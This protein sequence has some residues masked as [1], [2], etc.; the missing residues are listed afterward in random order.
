MTEDL[1]NKT[2]GVPAPDAPLQPAAPP[3][4]RAAPG[5]GAPQASGQGCAPSIPDA[6]GAPNAHEPAASESSLPSEST[7][8]SGAAQPMPEA[9]QFQAPAGA[10]EEETQPAE[11][12]KPQA[13]AMRPNPAVVFLR[14][15]AYL[16]LT[17]AIAAAGVYGGYAVVKNMAASE[18][19][20]PLLDG[21]PFSS[22]LYSKEG[23][24]MRVTPAA[25]GIFRVRAPLESIDKQVVDATIAYEDKNFWKHPGFDAVALIRSAVSTYIGGARTGASTL[26]MQLARM[27]LK[28]KTDTPEGKLKQIWHA[29]RY[30][31]HYSKREILEAYLNLAPYGS[32]VEGVEAAAAVWFHKTASHLTPAEAAALAVIPQN[33]VKR[34][35]DPVG[36][37]A[38]DAARLRLSKLLVESGAY[39]PSAASA[40]RAPLEVFG[41]D[42]LP[43]LAPH[44]AQTVLTRAVGTKKTS[45]A[46]GTTE[47][48]DI[49]PDVTSGRTSGRLSGTLSLE[50]QEAMEALVRETISR[51]APWGV[52]N[53]AISVVDARDR[54]VLAMVGSADFFDS[55]IQGEVNAWSAK[56]SPGSLLK[57]FTYALALDQ[58][59]IHEKTVL[60]DSPQAYGGWAPENADGGFRGPL[61]AEDALVLSRNIPAID[62]ERRLNPGLYELLQRAGAELPHE[63]SWYGLSIVLGGAEITMAD[64]VKLYAMLAGDGLLRPLKL[65]QNDPSP[66]EAELI[67]REAQFVL[68]REQ[69][70]QQ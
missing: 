59:L 32:N 24:L 62:L 48:S 34:R 66:A 51:L 45:R 37:T 38:L 61:A 7:Q 44:Y 4:K 12:P 67:S 54:S 42:K 46:V 13:K 58:G 10:S 43:F 70:F 41:P 21:V 29:M 26:T 27:R 9:F 18:A 11:E 31:A 35:P 39:P 56:R 63:K 57:P 6:P 2:P 15:T 69:C 28:L 52:S 1:S 64:A 30:E 25:D 68:K 22:S 55:A 14:R 47:D 36:N 49:K 65:L 60:I 17:A 3:E 19:A 53:A 23:V 8:A 33:P 40:L 5:D 20:P 50:V 16:V